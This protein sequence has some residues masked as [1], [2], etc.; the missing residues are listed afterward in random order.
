MERKSTGTGSWSNWLLLLLL[1]TGKL[2]FD[3]AGCQEW[4]V[5]THTVQQLLPLWCLYPPS[6]RLVATGIPLER[7]SLL[8]ETPR[9]YAGHAR[10]ICDRCRSRRVLVRGI[11]KLIEI[12]LPPR[13]GGS[14]YGVR[15]S[16]QDPP[17]TVPSSLAK[18]FF[19][20]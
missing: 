12:L 7:Q 9:C 16:E 3:G 6:R 4:A 15:G 18:F 13:V 19:C 5:N 14:S 2:S 11:A 1:C 17:K 8:H 10:D 20:A